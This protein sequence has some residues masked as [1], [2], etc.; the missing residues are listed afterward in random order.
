LLPEVPA[1]PLR[2]EVPDSPLVPE[3]PDVPLTPEVPKEVPEVPAEPDEPEPPAPPAMKPKPSPPKNVVLMDFQFYMRLKMQNPNSEKRAP[4]LELNEKNPKAL[5][6]IVTSF[7]GL[8]LA[9]I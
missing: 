6:L 2:P 4:D 1:V 8:R 3:R 5:F 7:A 9:L